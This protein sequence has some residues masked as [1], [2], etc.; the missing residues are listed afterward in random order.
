MDISKYD[1]LIGWCNFHSYEIE[2]TPQAVAEFIVNTG[3]KALTPL[4]VR[5]ITIR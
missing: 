5:R 3:W 1:H 4:S 2:N